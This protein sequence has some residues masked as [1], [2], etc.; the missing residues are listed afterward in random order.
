MNSL[1]WIPII[2]AC[3]FTSPRVTTE[4]GLMLPYESLSLLRVYPPQEYFY[5]ILFPSLTSFLPLFLLL[6]SLLP[7][8]LFFSLCPPNKCAKSCSE[9]EVPCTSE[10]PHLTQR[11]F[12]P[13][14]VTAFAAVWLQPFYCCKLPA[15]D[16]FR[17][18]LSSTKPLVTAGCWT[19]C[20]TLKW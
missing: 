4:K 19:H 11:K 6:F 1:S 7:P 2:I 17:C 10:S 14:V 18:A 5:W 20:H 13:T 8:L 15:H 12:V 16:G 3:N 9:T